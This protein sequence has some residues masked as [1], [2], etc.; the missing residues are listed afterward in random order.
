MPVSTN[1]PS[2]LSL[3]TMAAIRSFAA[4]RAPAWVSSQDSCKTS[5]MNALVIYPLDL[6]VLRDLASR[7]GVRVLLRQPMRSQ[8]ALRLRHPA[9]NP[10]AVRDVAMPVADQG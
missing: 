9:G 8:L 10:R 3:S 5:A 1:R 4:T 6:V 7:A 2:C